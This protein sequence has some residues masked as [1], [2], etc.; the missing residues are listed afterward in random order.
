MSPVILFTKSGS[1][2]FGSSLKVWYWLFELPLQN[3]IS[4]L[5]RKPSPNFTLTETSTRTFF[6]TVVRPQMKRVTL[7]ER[8]SCHCMFFFFFFYRLRFLVRN[9]IKFDLIYIIPQGKVMKVKQMNGIQRLWS[10]LD[11]LLISTLLNFLHHLLMF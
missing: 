10:I 3:R 8:N 7:I 11:R 6:F 2:N 1:P 5:K 9:V 4:S